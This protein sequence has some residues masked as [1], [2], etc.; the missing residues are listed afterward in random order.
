M[1]GLAVCTQ[2]QPLP[3]PSEA[4]WHELRAVLSSLAEEAAFMGYA[5]C[6]LRSWAM[7]VQRRS[8]AGPKSATAPLVMT[9]MQQGRLVGRMVIERA[10]ERAVELACEMPVPPCSL[11]G[12]QAAEQLWGQR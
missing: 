6:T 9:L 1:N 8:I 4:D 3:A 5:S 11:M 10:I 2:Q 7:A 12:R